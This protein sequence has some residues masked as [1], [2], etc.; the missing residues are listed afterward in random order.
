MSAP[1]RKMILAAAS[2]LVGALLFTAQAP[3]DL[4]IQTTDGIREIVGEP[5]MGVELLN[6]EEIAA[7]KKAVSEISRM[8]FHRLSASQISRLKTVIHSSGI[9]TFA[10]P[11]DDFEDRLTVVKFVDGRGFSVE[12]EIGSEA[13]ERTDYIILVFEVLR[14][15][16]NSTVIF[17]HAY[18]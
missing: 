18:T 15:Q 14:N 11:A 6:R 17:S 7:V 4:R 1:N 16:D 2:T 5:E 12:Y 8:E 13:D 10:Q 3:A 9:E